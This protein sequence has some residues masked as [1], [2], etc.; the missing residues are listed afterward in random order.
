MTTVSPT[1]NIHHTCSTI[2]GLID[3][4]RLKVPVTLI[5]EDRTSRISKVNTNALTDSGA[6]GKFIDQNYAQSLG[7]KQMALEELIKVLNVDGT[8]NK[9]GTITHFTEINLQIGN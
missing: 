8:Q 2:Y 5:Y 6:E 9:R 3:N 4:K 7:I 1:L